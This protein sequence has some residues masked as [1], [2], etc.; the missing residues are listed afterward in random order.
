MRESLRRLV[1]TGSDMPNEEEAIAESRAAVE[2][3]IN[4]HVIEG[5][6]PENSFAKE[7]HH[8]FDEIHN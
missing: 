8:L 5:L 7:A 1:A 6:S 3:F 4:V 2:S